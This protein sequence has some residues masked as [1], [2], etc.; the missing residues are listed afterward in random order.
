[1]R[2]DDPESEDGSVTRWISHLKGG[3][4]R[5]ASQLWERYFRR[6]KGLARASLATPRGGSPTRRMSP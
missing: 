2:S 3:D 6:L 4:E 5:V 1:M